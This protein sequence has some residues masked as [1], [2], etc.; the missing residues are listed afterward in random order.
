MK[1]TCWSAGSA[2]PGKL[3]R[4]RPALPAV[5]L[6]PTLVPSQLLGAPSQ[7]LLRATFRPRKTVRLPLGPQLRDTPIMSNLS[8][9]SLRVPVLDGNHPE[10]C[11][12]PGH[13][14]QNAPQAPDALGIPEPACGSHILPLLPSTT[15]DPGAG[16]CIS[17]PC[18]PASPL[19]HLAPRP[20]PPTTF[21]E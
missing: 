7:L 19:S 4:L 9:Q 1:C 13:P 14:L 21:T 2:L 3:S 17:G 11:R 10:T 12:S 20:P 16:V 6:L 8:L 18:P 5:G 15:S